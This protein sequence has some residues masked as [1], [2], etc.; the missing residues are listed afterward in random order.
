MAT[1]SKDLERSPQGI[2]P[3]TL[4]KSNVDEILLS[5]VIPVYNEEESL[6]KLFE[7]LQNSLATF[8]GPWEVILID[9]G[10]QDDTLEK[11]K[12]IVSLNTI[13]QLRGI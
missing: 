7:A 4:D 10:S 12:K 9:D 3:P 8:P 11:L 1:S 6:H 13:L 5:V 2:V